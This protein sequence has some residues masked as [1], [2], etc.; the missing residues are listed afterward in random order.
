MKRGLKVEFNAKNGATLKLDEV[1][2]GFAASVQNGMVN[3]GQRKQSSP[4]FPE[5]GTGLHAAALRGVLI[6]LTDATHHANF[7][8][9]DTLFFSR[10]T[11]P[12]AEEDGALASV[13]LEP[14]ELA[15]GR[16]R[17]RARFESNS[18]E[19]VGITGI[20]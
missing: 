11:D 18:G 1:V 19:A 8:A 12:D 7:A 6:S 10:E 13:E 2:T 16:L 3:L 4:I 14:I 17:V 5:K 9:I 15:S 20:L